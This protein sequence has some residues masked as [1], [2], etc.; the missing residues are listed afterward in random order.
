[1]H[2]LL[3]LLRPVGSAGR[4]SRDGLV[5]LGTSV[6]GYILRPVT[7]DAMFWNGPPPPPRNPDPASTS[8]QCERTGSRLAR[9]YTDTA[10]G[11]WECQFLHNGELAYSR[12]WVS[13]ADALAESEEKRQELEGEG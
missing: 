2:K 7:G 9:S 5:A 4:H 6:V 8:G 13:W 11:G 3:T 1:M 10:S 12:R